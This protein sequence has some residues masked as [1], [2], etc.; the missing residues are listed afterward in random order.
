MS[1]PAARRAGALLVAL[2][3]ALGVAACAGDPPQPVRATFP[4]VV[5]LAVG[6]AVKIADVQV[7]R[8][9]G[10]ELDA[11]HQALV[12][13][14]IDPDVAL[15][16]RLAARVKKTGVLGERFVELVPDPEAGGSWDDEEVIAGDLVPDLEELVATSTDLLIAISADTLAGAIEAGAEGLDGRGEQLGGI[17]D[18]LEAVTATYHANSDDLTRLITGL[19]EFVAT[20]GSQ[21]DLH[22][23][24]LAEAAEFTTVLAEEDDRLIDALLDLQDL[25][26]TGEDLIRTH[27]QRMDDVVVR[28]NRLTDEIVERLGDLDSLLPNWH[29][30]NHNTIRGVNAEHAQVI[31]DFIVCGLN[32]QPGDPVR[33]CTDPP[34]AFTP[35]VRP[36][37]EW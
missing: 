10:I 16:S 31:L 9:T 33:A 28:V 18:D 24:A 29:Q 2:A 23:R 21:A 8:V 1:T 27:R 22:G 20:T 5:D 13:M 17:L 15:P 36:P 26:V 30:H 4:D 19:E 32:D 34:Q 37:Q 12:T 25:A 3:C 14:A 7:G 35:D 6:G 11:D